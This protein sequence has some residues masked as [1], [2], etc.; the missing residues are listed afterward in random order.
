MNDIGPRDL[1]KRVLVLPA[2][3]KDFELT[4]E[5]L[6]RAGIQG[7]SCVELGDLIEKA[8][9]GAGA[10]LIVEEAIVGKQGKRLSAFLTSQPSWSEIPLLILA[11]S[12][13]D[14]AGIANAM[15]EYGNVTVLERPTRIAAL[16]SAVRSALRARSRQY[17]VRDDAIALEA[18]RDELENRVKTR[19]VE[20][21]DANR[22]L[23]KKMMETEAAERRAYS[24]LRELV[25]AQES[26]RARIARDLHDEL[27]QQITSLRL[28]LTNL[29]HN[30]ADNKN[31]DPALAL[32]EH[33]A[34]K[35]DT[36]V[37][38]LAWKIRPTSIEELGLSEALAG[39][40]REWSRNVDIEAEFRSGPPL[41]NRLLP[42][43]EVNVYRIMQEAL[44]N[45]AKYAAATQVAV[46]LATDDKKLSLIV[47]DNGKGFDTGSLQSSGSDGGL[48][49][50][51]MQERASLLG[52]IFE[53]E[54]STRTGTAVY[55]NIP[56]RFR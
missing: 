46:L 9:K 14:S 39:Y 23:E 21:R 56:A 1:E 40:I 12:G 2:T 30:L 31:L 49:I 48:G 32:I 27:G 7:V 51:G 17:Q 26:E 47:E 5:V 18:A 34:E 33:Q 38:F 53:I 50:S 55:V 19:T 6:H 29:E 10:I 13:A 35:I 43:I 20:L 8:K 24:L 3:T 54:S 37:S 22:R 42:E 4:R 11:R 52:G 36:Q 28:Q 15:D 41:A 44:N 16:V 25:T 45:V